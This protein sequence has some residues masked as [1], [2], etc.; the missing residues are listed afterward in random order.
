MGLLCILEIEIIAF[1]DCLVPAKRNTENIPV[2]F[3]GKIF[4][5]ILDKALV[6]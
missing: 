4:K 6:C 3:P 2:I 1:S 5:Y